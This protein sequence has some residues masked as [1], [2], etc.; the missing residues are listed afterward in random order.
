MIKN[1]NNKADLRK[2]FIGLRDSITSADRQAAAKKAASIFL[3]NIVVKRDDIVSGYYPFNSEISPL[4]LMEQLDMSGI[5]TCLP[6]ITNRNEPLIFKAWQ[7]GNALWASGH[8]N[9]KEPAASAPKVTPTI[10]ILPLLAFDKS[11]N[12]LGYGGGFYD[13]TMDF[14]K[15]QGHKPIAV[16]LAYSAQL[17]QSLPNESHDHILDF[18]VTESGISKF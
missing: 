13:R 14:F 8:F 4:P 16:G 7:C 1:P 10:I 18:V 11:G 3:Q 9:L 12:R 6:V 5:T 17:A 15:R 2:H